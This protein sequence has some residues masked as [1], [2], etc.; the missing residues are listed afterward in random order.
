M[1]K[2]DQA[3]DEEIT[4]AITRML[5]KETGQKIFTMR[6]EQVEADDLALDTIV[7]MEDK[8]VLK[9]LISIQTIDGKMACRMQL[10]YV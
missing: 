9:G 6:V 8:S 7:V 1:K 4:E 3:P 2:F 5:E 10:N